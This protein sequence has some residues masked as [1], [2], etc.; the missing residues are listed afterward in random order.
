MLSSK[1][2]VYPF[3]SL[4]FGFIGCGHIAQSFIK[5]YLEY[6]PLLNKKIFISGRNL[7]KTKRISEKLQVQMVLDN[8]ELLEKASVIF[9]CIKPQDAEQALQNLTIHFQSR[10]TILSLVAGISFKKL[11]KWGLTSHRLIRLMPNTSVRVN[12][13]M[14]PFCSLN[15]QDSLNSFVEN[16][17][18]PLGQILILKEETLL[19]PVTVGSASGLAFVFE[20]MEYWLEWLQGEGFTYKQSKTLVVETF[21]GAATLCKK[22]QHKSFSDL[23]KEV[24]SPKGVSDSGLKKMRELEL[25]RTLRLSFET[26]CLKVKELE[27]EKKS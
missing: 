23:Q 7:K 2:A 22:R 19:S 27:K 9:L 10:H 11:K 1:K 21:L 26:A 16:L 24:V 3:H 14:L 17:L 4:N 5:G 25:E 15:N 6:S 8:E 13:G 20:L 18:E 12:Q